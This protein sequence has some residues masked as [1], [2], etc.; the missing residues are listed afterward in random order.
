MTRSRITFT[1]PAPPTVADSNGSLLFSPI[2]P[3]ASTGPWP[4]EAEGAARQPQRDAVSLN[5]FSAPASS[6]LVEFSGYPVE[7]KLRLSGCL[8][9]GFENAIVDPVIRS[10][11]PEQHLPLCAKLP[12]RLGI[13]AFGKEP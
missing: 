8:T 4:V 7:D 12:R 9:V 2:P 10:G 3:P 11:V 1:D 13:G 6:S 5:Y